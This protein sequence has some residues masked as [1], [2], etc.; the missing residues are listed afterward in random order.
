VVQVGNQA[1]Q[2]EQLQA[3][4][5]ELEQRVKDLRTSRLVLMNLL[6]QR[7]IKQQEELKALRQKNEELLEIK[8][9]YSQKLRAQTLKLQLLAAART[10]GGIDQR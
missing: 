10:E 4:I 1:D 7:E 2:L 8:N 6:Q 3:R 5:E 9:Q